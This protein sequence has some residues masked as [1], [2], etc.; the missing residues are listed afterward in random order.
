M[1]KIFLLLAMVL[2]VSLTSICSASNGKLLDAE[3]AL[4]NKFLLSSN[5]SAVTE[6]M[7]DEMKQDFTADTYK[8]FKEQIAKDF[9]KIKDNR[10]LVV[11]KGNNADMLMYQAAYEKMPAVRLAFVFTIT[12]EKPLLNKFMLALPPKPQEEAAPAQK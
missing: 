10:L 7:T 6:I 5:Y 8:N 12:N 11:E 1:K 3:E 2:M 9:G 4:V